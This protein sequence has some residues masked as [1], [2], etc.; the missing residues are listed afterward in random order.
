MASGKKKST[1][2]RLAYGLTIMVYGIVFLLSET[3]ILAKIPYIQHL[4]GI[5]SLFMIAGIVFLCFKTE[6]TI[7]IILTAIGVV[8]NISLFFGWP[9]PYS[10]LFAPLLLIIAGLIMVL[11]TKK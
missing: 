6:K 5:G 9:K 8:I 3:G 4:T 11:S 7:G 10:Y 2:N 1:E